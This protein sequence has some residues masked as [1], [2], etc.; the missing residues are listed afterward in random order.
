[1]HVGRWM[2]AVLVT[3]GVVVGSAV[4]ADAKSAPQLKTRLTEYKIRPEREALAKGATNIVAKNAGSAKHE[5]I[6]VR[7]DDP[8]ALP[9][10]PDGSVDESQIPAADKMGEVGGIKPGTT[11]SKV[12]KLRP[13]SYI[14]F[15]NIVDKTS[16]G[17]VSHFHEGMYTTIEVS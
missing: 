6:V 11:K 3:A 1:V 12:F 8:T 10:K 15:C 7:G 2:V 5:L 14:F 16:T 13:G 4:P 9:I 17:E